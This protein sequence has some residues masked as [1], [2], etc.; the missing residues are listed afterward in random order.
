MAKNIIYKSVDLFGNE[1][2]H[3]IEKKKKRDKTLFDDYEAFVDK[4]ED[5][6]T[7]FIFSAPNP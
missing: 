5:K 4:F 3:L 7:L 1:T 6:K 2:M